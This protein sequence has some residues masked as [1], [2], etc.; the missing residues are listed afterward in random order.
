[1]RRWLMVCA[2]VTLMFGACSVAIAQ[3]GSASLANNQSSATPYVKPESSLQGIGSEKTV[4]IVAS[5]IAPRALAVDPGANVYLTNAAAPSRVFTLTGLADLVANATSNPAVPVRLALVA[6]VGTAG[7]LGDGGS[8]LAAQFALKLDSLWMRSGV[9]VAADGTIFVA[10][11][12]NLTIR[13][14]AGADSSEQGVVRSIAGRWAAKQNIAL[15]EPLGI[16]L[17]RAGD[18]YVA[19]RA[20]GAVDVLPTATTSSV[21]DQR[22]D[23]LAHMVLPANIALTEDGN[24]AFVGSPETGAVFEIDTQTRSLRSLPPFPAPKPPTNGQTV[25]A[26][27]SSGAT[28]DGRGAVC[29][30][31]LAVDGGGNLFVADANSGRILRVDAETTQLTTVATGLRS[32]GDMSFDSSG[33]LYVAE[34]GAN[35]IVKFVSMGQDPNN[36]TITMPASLTPPPSPRVCPPGPTGAFN[37]CDQ[38]TGGSTATQA[39]TLTNNSS[40][41][42]S[43]IAISFKGSNPGDF[44]ASSSTCGT[45]LAAGASCAINVDFSPTATGLRSATL[46]VTDST[47][48][49]DLATASVAGTGDD[50]EIV[51]NGSPME[52]SVVQGGTLKFNFNIAPDSVF[53]GDVTIVCPSDLPSLSACTPSASTVTVTPG[54]PA[55]FSITFQTTYNGVLG[56]FPTNGLVPAVM[57]HRDRKTPGSPVTISWILAAVFASFAVIAFAR[58]RLRLATV[59]QPLPAQAF[60][61]ATLLFT[62]ALASL[63]GCKHHSV[64]ANLNTPAGVTNLIVQG[65]AQ[66][67]GR[68]ITI[69]LDVVTPG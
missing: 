20:A 11:T 15:A 12:L 27:A 28:H 68:G 18:L 37:F 5:G 30:A 9:V 23:V 69:I 45:S 60:W 66:N 65:T 41:A 47:N 48:A 32:P 40:A 3:V 13:R 16:A 50:Y 14:I 4:V 39:F 42:I 38:P 64:P 61:I 62:C 34:Q 31:G 59:A 52:Q 43:G 54:S 44:Q 35:R 24:K 63:S 26:C 29:P 33:N 19:D 58:R 1:M 57:I 7:S 53:G 8:A 56:G 17:D 25:F 46:S 6:G 67:A 51:L 2:A 21:G 10:D 55:P 49:S 22:V 36:L